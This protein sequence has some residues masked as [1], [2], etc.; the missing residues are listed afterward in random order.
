[1]AAYTQANR[2]MR[3]DTGL[4]EDV[5]LLSGFNGH[6]G[7]SQLFGF[8]LDMYSIDAE[9]DAAKLLREPVMV[10]MELPGGEKRLVHG[11]MS[12]LTQ[13]G[14][15]EDLM[16]YRA[17]IVPWLWFLR[18]ARGSRMFQEMSVP[19]ILEKVFADAGYSDFEFRLT[20]SYAPRLYCV[21]YRE[22][23]LDFVSRLMEEE[24]IFYFFEHYED[25]HV[26]VLC[27]D[28][29]STKAAPA[30]ETARFTADAGRDEEVIRELERE[31][32]VHT[33]KVTVRD[34]DYLQPSLNLDAS[35]G[36]DKFEIYDYPGS[37]NDKELGE[38]V[39]EL[40]LEA[41]E[42]ERQVL[43]GE[44]NVRGLIAGYHFELKDHFR[45]DA[46][47]K[48][49]VTQI[50]HYASAGGFRS[51][52][53]NSPLEY[54]NDFLAIPHDTPFRPPRR[55]QRPLIHGS[56][57][58]LVVGPAGEEI[59]VDKYGR[60]KV[61]FYW[62]RDSRRDEHSSCWIRVTTPWGGKGYGTVS[63]PR[64]GN[65]VIVAFEE[66]DPDRPIIIGSVYNGEQTPP[67]E[68]PGAGIQMGMK[69]RSSP[70]GGGSNEINM[71]DT[72]GKEKI[73]IHGQYDMA[74]TVENDQ[75]N[76]VN[77]NRTT[78]I[79][80][81]DTESIGSNQAISVGADQSL[82]AGGN[83]KIDVAGN[84]DVS[85]GG[86]QTLGVGGNESVDVGGDRTTS[87]GGKD[88]LTVG[89][90]HAVDVG[91]N[92]TIS[93]GANGELT[94]GANH[95][96]DAGAQIKINAGATIE[97]SA[98]AMITLEAG[99]SKVEIGPAGVTI[100]TGAI[101]SVQGATIKLN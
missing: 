43:R 60:V 84:R 94:V 50:Q 77:N 9:I 55:T 63:V 51:R 64:I 81:D 57:S 7:V 40:L 47:G 24:G 80:V 90:D 15:H 36:D 44:G 1:M 26:L 71:T 6:E 33:G 34:Y 66:G 69:S 20:H 25:R 5:L 59:H 74:T 12:R 91:V 92:Q 28:N 54:H 3:V 82:S 38:R 89:G 27:D 86:N 95:T 35:L 45:R 62:D 101:V 73:T 11:L 16:N 88:A 29:S 76:T 17:E 14:K 97:I 78:T 49:I 56:Q 75:T 48:Y 83:Q 10:S 61:H 8:Q 53:Q 70:G 72:K 67:F 100:Q 13:L 58:A 79:A 52:E 68:L 4:G 2:P 18:L 39:A 21:Q 98:G 23:H 19:D 22:T 65:E 99:G 37:Y 32:S 42:A 31:H 93:V 46:N 30:A 96:I 41:E 85:V 87:I